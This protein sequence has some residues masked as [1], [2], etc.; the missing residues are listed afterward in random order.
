ML[1]LLIRILY[2]DGAYSDFTSVNGEYSYL[3]MYGGILLLPAQETLFFI[4]L[5]VL[6]V[7]SK[8]NTP[9]TVLEERPVVSR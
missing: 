1:I 5:T 7:K 4:R 3:C 6:F 9:V 8:N 2:F